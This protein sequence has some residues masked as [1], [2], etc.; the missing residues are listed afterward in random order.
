MYK[1]ML[2]LWSDHQFRQQTPTSFSC[3]S[4]PAPRISGY[5]VRN[6]ATQVIID[7]SSGL[8]T[9]TSVKT[10]LNYEVLPALGVYE[11]KFGNVVAACQ[12]YILNQEEKFS[13]EDTGQKCYH[14]E[15]WHFLKKKFCGKVAHVPCRSFQGQLIIHRRWCMITQ[16]SCQLIKRQ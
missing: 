12:A 3:P 2:S 13:L 15:K 9:S 8:S 6:W 11:H 16:A 7:F 5:C 14:T 1:R 4:H 10:K